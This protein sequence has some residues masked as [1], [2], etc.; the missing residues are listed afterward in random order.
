M[1]DKD[2][3]DEI[4]RQWGA[5]R[6]DLDASPIAVIGRVS[7]LSR[8]I[9]RRLAMNFADFGIENWMYDVLATLR[10]QGAP[11]TMT[12]GDLIAHTMVTSGA[13]TNRID[14]LEQ[15][16]WV[17]RGSAPDRRQVLVRL[18]DSGRALVDQVVATHL[19]TEEHILA[20]ISPRQRA[21]LTAILRS[22]LVDLDDHP[23][24]KVDMT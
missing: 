4:V 1:G 24:R 3:V 7:R 16:G 11:F 18:T 2:L 22:L 9:D 21:T 19:A 10:R 14:R 6:P 20:A 5:V 15:S 17:E 23:P 8:L 12:A 13:M